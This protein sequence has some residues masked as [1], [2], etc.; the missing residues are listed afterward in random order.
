VLVLEKRFHLIKEVLLAGRI[1]LGFEIGK[2]LEQVFLFFGEADGCLD[3]DTDEEIAE[4]LPVDK[5]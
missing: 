5:E 2:L 4:A 3:R 1:A